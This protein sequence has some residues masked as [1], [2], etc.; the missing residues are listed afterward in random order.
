METYQLKLTL[1][2]DTCFSRGDGVAGYVDTEIKY[3]RYGIPY[4]DG[5]TVKGLLTAACAEILDAISKSCAP[6]IFE[7]YLHMAELLFGSPGSKGSSAK[8]RIGKAKLPRDLSMA[9]MR[10]FPQAITSAERAKFQNLKREYLEAFTVIRRQTAMDESG[11]P[12]PESL[13]AI[14][15]IRRELSFSAFVES[16]IPL[17]SDELSLMAACAKTLTRS[18]SGRNRGSGNINVNL[19]HVDGSVITQPSAARFTQEVLT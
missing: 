18:G 2:S 7:K 10:E 15:L 4:V 16:E 14:R 11:A 3:D 6:D 12:K 17:N 9:I 8:L 1:L 13:R 5:R 19:L